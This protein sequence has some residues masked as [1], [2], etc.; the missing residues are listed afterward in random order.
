MILSSTKL[1]IS[2]KVHYDNNINSP[3]PDTLA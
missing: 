1:N 3:S 2:I